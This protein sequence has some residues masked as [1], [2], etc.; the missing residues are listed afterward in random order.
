MCCP[1]CQGPLE[2]IEW[3]PTY[4]R[5]VCENQCRGEDSY[6]CHHCP[7]CKFPLEGDE[8]CP[9]CSDECEECGEFFRKGYKG[10]CS[11]GC[12]DAYHRAYKHHGEEARWIAYE[13]SK[14]D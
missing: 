3:A 12:Y 13:E 6:D 8:Q 5:L 1:D 11:E 7:D 9:N 10:F 4:T 14:W 2:E